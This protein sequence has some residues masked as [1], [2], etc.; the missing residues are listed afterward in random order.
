MNFYSQISPDQVIMSHSPLKMFKQFQDKHCLIS[1][2]GPILEIA[3]GY[4][5]K[6]TCYLFV[7]D[8]Y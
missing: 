8:I 3:K 1:G 2:Q 5:C 6:Y 7:Q 4:V